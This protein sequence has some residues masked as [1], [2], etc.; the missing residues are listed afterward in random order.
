MTIVHTTFSAGDGETEKGSGV[1]QVGDEAES[2][3]AETGWWLR[4][5]LHNH[6]DSC[7]LVLDGE[8]RDTSI[9]ALEAQVDQ[10]GCLRC[11]DVTLDVHGLRGIDAVGANVLLGL[12]HYVDGRGGRLRIVGATERIG[13]ALHQF[14]LEYSEADDELTRTLDG[15][16]PLESAGPEC[17]PH[18][19]PDRTQGA[20]RPPG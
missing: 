2:A 17:A 9:A 15:S 10:L 7:T 19:G 12:H 13:A 14:A 20:H 5:E 1:N 6:L 4:V 3:E 16:A 11:D 18:V 8:L